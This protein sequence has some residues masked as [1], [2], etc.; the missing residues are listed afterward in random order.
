MLCVGCAAD[1]AGTSSEVREVGSAASESRVITSLDPQ[2]RFALGDLKGAEAPAFDDS[3]WRK[4]DV[5]HDWSIEGPFDQNN[6]TRGA[7]AFLPGGVGWYRKTFDLPASNNGRRVFLEFDG[8]MANS[9][10]WVNGQHVGHRPFGY[11]SLRYDVTKHAKFGGTNLVAVRAD[12]SNQPASRWYTGAGIYRHARLVT[13]DA[14]HLVGDGTYV[15]TPHV[16]PGQATVLVS[17]EAKNDSAKARQLSLHVELFGPDGKSVGT[18]E[19]PAQS[20]AAGAMM[21]LSAQLWV[22]NPRRWH[23]GRGILYR[24]AVSLREAGVT[25][26][27][28]SIP[29]GI[30]ELRFEP[31]LGFL[32]NVENVKIKGVCLHHDGGAVG[33]AV[34][35]GIWEWRLKQLQSLGVN[36][37]RTAHN[38]PDPQF[39]DLCDRM[40]LMVMDEMFD[41]W[42]VGKNRYDYH[43]YFN[44]WSKQDLRDTVRRDRNHPSVIIYSAGNEIHDT[45]RAELAKGILKGLV[46]EFHEHDPYRLVT[47][48]LFR[49]NVSHDYHNGLADLLDV[50]G[51]N[52][53]ERELQDA[54]TQKPTRRILGTENQHNRQVW[55]AL[56]DDPRMA[57][58]FLWSGIDYLGESRNWPGNTSGSGLLDRTGALKMQAF[59]R[60]S[61]WSAQPMVHAIR[62]VAPAPPPTT[63]PGYEA[64]ATPAPTQRRQGPSAFSDWTPTNLETH[65]EMVEVYSNCPSVELFLND[66]SLGALSLPADASARSWKVSFAPG[67]LRAVGSKDGTEQARYEMR[68][69]GTATGIRLKPNQPAIGTTWDDVAIIEAE[70]ID[71]NGVKLPRANH[72]VYFE[73]DGP[74]QIIAVDN[75]DNRSSQSFGGNLRPA[76]QGRCVAIIRATADGGTIT[77]RAL[78]AGLKVGE[79]TVQI[80]G[81]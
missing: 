4:L 55:L 60:R 24:A 44:E 36:A 7:G 42:T 15:A 64:P 37:I 78:A 3:Q 1:Q 41:C 2:W 62:R 52:Y 66:R 57:G 12:N 56:R 38:P 6:P 59:E 51:Q 20:V 69:A 74:G 19:S 72:P 79:T 11:V 61:W 65:D 68:T 67:V 71:E 80:T 32:I 22:E 9:D 81:K 45:P 13:T 5:P 33:A 23:V 53:R 58:Q 73:I 54:A 18:S 30:R 10:V 77:I 75:A 63:D 34:P 16:L 39:L 40:G 48:A 17:A 8:I 25:R 47:Q 49:P 70:I 31:E 27:E 21:P 50:V 35:L 43:Q 46:D 14:V 76:H 26:D 29:F 28:E